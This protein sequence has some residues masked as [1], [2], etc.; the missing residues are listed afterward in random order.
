MSDWQYSALFGNTDNGHDF[1]NDEDDC[2][3]VGFSWGD[4][5]D[6]PYDNQRYVSRHTP[7][8]D[9]LPLSSTVEAVLFMLWRG[10]RLRESDA[11]FAKGLLSFAIKRGPL[12]RRQIEA[13][14]KMLVRYKADPF[15]IDLTDFLDTY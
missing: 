1:Y 13:A 12:T 7:D 9:P 2:S 6:I 10:D 14:I 11:K 3:D 5:E 15:M 8:V 4:Y